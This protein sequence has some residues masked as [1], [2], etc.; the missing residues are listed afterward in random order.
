MRD[1]ITPLISFNYGMN[2]KNR[3]NT[4]IKYGLIY[5][6]VVMVIGILVLEIFA[7]P[8][9]KMFGLSEHTAQLCV[10]ASRIIA[11]GF[12]LQGEI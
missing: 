4:G 7:D 10:T 2:D 11:T 3:V 8:L 5:T 9:V 12:Y 1:T 6:S